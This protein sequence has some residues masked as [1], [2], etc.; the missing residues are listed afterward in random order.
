MKIEEAIKLVKYLMGQ[1]SNDPKEFLEMVTAT[2]DIHKASQQ[3]QGVCKCCQCPHGV[4]MVGQPDHEE[5][6]SENIIDYQRMYEHE[7]EQKDRAIENTEASDTK[8]VRYKKALEA[9]DSWRKQMFPD[10][11]PTRFPGKLL[12][13]ALR[14]KA[15]TPTDVSQEKKQDDN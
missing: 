10:N 3:A 12:A 13:E 11:M 8:A 1:R 9:I 7:R 4:L 2:L 15:Q 6:E 5:K 14:P